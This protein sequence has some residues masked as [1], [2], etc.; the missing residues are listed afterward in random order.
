LKE[1]E[2]YLKMGAVV[3]GEC[4]FGVDCDSKEMQKIYELAQKYNV[5]ILMHWLA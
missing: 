1:I 3:V 4:K 2:K 5:P